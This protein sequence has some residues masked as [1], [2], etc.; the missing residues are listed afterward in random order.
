MSRIVLLTIQNTTI[1]S[2]CKSVIIISRSEL[3]SLPV[4]CILLV[5]YHQTLSNEHVVSTVP[6]PMLDH[7][8]LARAWI[9]FTPHH[10]QDIKFNQSIR[11]EYRRHR[12]PMIRM[13]HILGACRIVSNSWRVADHWIFHR[14]LHW[15]IDLGKICTPLIISLSQQRQQHV[16]TVI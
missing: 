9:S 3:H 7:K 1:T 13:D 8:D 16:V 4:Q 15:N 11:V 2:Y 10:T 14:D 6:I 5:Q 12:Y